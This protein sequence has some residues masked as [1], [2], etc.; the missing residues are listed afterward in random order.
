MARWTIAARQEKGEYRQ[1][2][3]LI[4][5]DTIHSNGGR[6]CVALNAWHWRPSRASVVSEIVPNMRRRRHVMLR[7]QA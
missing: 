4:E 3:K 2:G 1:A 6:S 5:P 7:H